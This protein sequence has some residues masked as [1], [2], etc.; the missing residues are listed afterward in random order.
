[1]RSRFA[2]LAATGI[3]FIALLVACLMFVGTSSRGVL[4]QRIQ[5][6]VSGVK[7][8]ERLML[9]RNSLEILRDFPIF[10][11]GLGCWPEIFPKYRSAP[12]GEGYF[13][14]AHNDYAQFAV[15]TGVVGFALLLW[16]IVGAGLRFRGAAKSLRSDVAPV[17]FAL[18]GGMVGMGLHEFVDFSLHMPANAILLIL[19]IGLALRIAL[20]S[21]AS[22][23][24]RESAASLSIGFAYSATAAFAV[25]AI[26]SLL[27]PKF[28]YPYDFERVATS[29]QARSLIESHPGSAYAHALLVARAGDTIPPD[30][31]IS[32]LQIAVWLQ[33]TNPFIRDSLFGLLYQ[34]GRDRDANGALADA[35]YYA[36][37][38]GKHFYLRDRIISLLSTGQRDAIEL[39]YK[40]AIA[41][42]YAGA[43]DGLAWFYT[44]TNEPYRAGSLYASA[45]ESA[46]NRPARQNYLLKAGVAYAKAGMIKQAEDEFRVAVRNVPAD[47]RA[48]EALTTQ[49][50][51]PVKDLIHST[52]AIKQGIA[53]GADPFPLYQSLALAAQS[54]GNLSVAEIAEEQAL[55]IRPND[56]D[57]IARLA[58]IFMAESKFGEASSHFQRVTEINPDSAPAFFDLANAQASAFQFYAAEQSFRRAI[59]LQPDNQWYRRRYSEFQKRLG[60][61]GTPSELSYQDHAEG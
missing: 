23:D 27:Q 57:G 8:E 34:A 15:E 56:A 60:S 61:A 54:A 36:P 18:F 39:G 46:Q 26:A 30:R 37:D 53:A 1:M 2:S 16:L 49:V 58:R 20:R 12:W 59:R 4:D 24:Q 47:S 29:L 9:W 41:A 21:G 32:E 19:L 50:Y 44:A 40:R 55:Q 3:L 25:L 31:K 10:G 6:T 11:V 42:K 33:P 28:S 35:V 5:Q 14:E 22:V 38:P 48:Y 43:L 45:A 7:M 52:E 13:R 17:Y 51:S